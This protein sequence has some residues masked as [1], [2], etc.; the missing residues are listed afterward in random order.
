MAQERARNTELGYDVESEEEDDYDI[1][2]GGDHRDHPD[3]E[4]EPEADVRSK[5]RQKTQ[6]KKKKK[7][8]FRFSKK[9][10]FFHNLKYDRALFEH[11]ACLKVLEVVDKAGAVYEMFIMVDGMKLTIR[12]STKLVPN[13]PLASFQK[14]FQL[15]SSL[16]K[17][18]FAEYKFY[19]EQNASDE[20]KCSTVDYISGKLFDEN[21]VKN[22]QKRVKY[23]QDLDEFLISENMG[24]RESDGRVYFLPWLF[25]KHYL[26][27]DVL[28]LAAGLQALQLEMFSI[29]NNEL[30]ILHSMTLP[31]FSNKFMGWN[32]AFDDMYQLKLSLRN[33]QRRA[34]FGGRTF[35]NPEYEGKRCSGEFEYLD[36]ISLYPSAIVFICQELGGFPTGAAKLLS[37]AQLNMDHLS[38]IASEYTVEIRIK[39][40]RKKQMSGIPFI[41]YKKADGS[42]D[43]VNEIPDGVDFLDCV[44]DKI[45]LEDWVEFHGIDF[46]IMGGIYWEGP[47]NQK[48]GEIM[49]RLHV[50]RKKCKDAGQTSKANLLK[51]T[52]NA[53]YGKTIQKPQNSQKKMIPVKKDKGKEEG[54]QL[55]LVNDFAT[56]ES[57]RFVGPQDAPH[58]VE[59][60]LSA[61]DVSFSLAQVGSKI[62]AASKRLMN[63]L[64]NLCSDMK[65]PIY[66]TDTD[67]FLVERADVPRVAA[68][69]QVKYGRA[70]LGCELGQ[71]HSDFTFKKDGKA[72]DPSYVHSTMFWPM[73]KK[74]YCHR[75]QANLPDGTVLH[76]IQYKAKECTEQGIVAKARSYNEE[77]ADEGMMALYQDLSEGKDIEVVLNPRCGKPR[78]EY[79]KDH[80]VSTHGKFF[81][82]TI[83]SRA[84][85]LRVASEKKTAAASSVTVEEIEAA[86]APRF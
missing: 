27:Y 73:G 62:L 4:S 71:F 57:F 52:S 40:I 50:E 61:L 15:H 33:F 72:V 76:S 38:T 39:A 78:F 66:Y 63:R 7:K 14:T 24:T 2:A 43:Y 34:V 86:L 83:R 26:A 10:L 54:Y 55:A 23:L 42:L 25:Y 1:L 19:T 31:S 53:A 48:F 5:K 36:A 12:D 20:F 85:Q 60:T 79:D 3:S 67:S 46:D 30:D 84:A 6:S 37:P 70:L 59:L 21:E 32:G 8:Q 35:V 58:Q 9:I 41:S 80:R 65:A 68:A 74:L 29:S 16:H 69:F 17:K 75:L 45:T 82:R 44:V 56:L 77:D 28:V 22:A 51:L 13:T 11:D 49:Q 18:D 81:T 64:F 47:K